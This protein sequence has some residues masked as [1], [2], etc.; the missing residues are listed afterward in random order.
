MKWPVVPRSLYDERTREL[1]DAN[2]EIRRLTQTIIDMK[3]TGATVRQATDGKLAAGVRQAPKEET[4]L[5]RALAL[6][7][8]TRTNAA[9][10]TGMRRWA[11]DRIAAGEKEEDVLSRV[12]SWNDP[13][14]EDEEEETLDQLLA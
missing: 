11:E 12:E 2:A 6:N 3:V 13:T 14:I 8:R 10:R 1:A 4:K 5:E 9:L 7:P